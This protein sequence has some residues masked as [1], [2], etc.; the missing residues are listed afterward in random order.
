M[1]PEPFLPG[2]NP[3]EYAIQKGQGAVALHRVLPQAIESVRSKGESLND[4][5]AYAEVMRNLPSL[6]GEI[7]T[8]MGPV[9]V[10]GPAFWRS[11][12]EG[13]ASQFSGD[14]GRKRLSVL[15]RQLMP[16]PAEELNF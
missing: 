12:P 10:E 9:P 2:T 8:D 7:V 13:V 11:G 6:S 3:K 15:I 16:K 4:P 5:S 14:A 1:L